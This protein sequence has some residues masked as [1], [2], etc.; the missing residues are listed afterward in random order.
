MLDSDGNIVKTTDTSYKRQVISEDV[1]KRMTAILQ[2]NATSESGKNGYVAGYRVAGKTGTSEKVALY[3]QDL[4]EGNDRGMH[5]VVSYGGYAPADDPQYDLLVFYDE[6]QIGGASGGT[7]AGPIF[8]AIMEEVLPYLGVDPQY[9]ESEYENLS[10]T[11]PNVIGMTMAE[12]KSHLEE[13]GFEDVGGEF[14]YIPNDL[15]DVSAEERET[16]NKMVEKLEEFDDV[17]TVYTN[18]KPEGE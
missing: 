2:K 18:M 8:A 6:P 14:T 7:Q 13:Q 16:L 1:S 9:T 5:Y 15:K 12:A 4:A 17:Q 11:A 10:A 3:Y